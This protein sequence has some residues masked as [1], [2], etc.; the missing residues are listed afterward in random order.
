MPIDVSVVIPVYNTEKYLNQCIDSLVNQTLRNVEFI[1]VDDGSTD[2]SVEIIEEYKKHDD[3]IRLIKQKNQYA[4]VA[5]NNGMK[6]A[7]G[8]YI[9]FLD[10]DDFFELNMLEDAFNCAEKN[11]AEIAVFWYSTYDNASKEVMSRPY[12]TLPENVFCLQEVGER[13]LNTIMAAPWNK[14]FLRSFVEENKLLFQPIEKCNDTYFTFIAAFLAK[15]I[16]FIKMR[17]VFYRTNNNESLQGNNNKKR[18]AFIDCMK[19]IKSKLTSLGLYCGTSKNSYLSYSK[20]LIHLYGSLH[21]AQ[22]DSY[23]EY[24][25]QL[26]SHMIPDL[27]DSEIDFEDDP[28]I[29]HLY[30]DSFEQFMFYQVVSQDGIIIELKKKLEKEYVS[31]KSKDYLIGHAVMA[32]PRAVRG[33]F[34]KKK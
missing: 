21:N 19:A 5:R 8:K 25:E 33:V 24:F 20:D 4:G 29:V 18:E 16:T 2:R 23:R 27:F 1:F 11:Q 6:V 15:R 34:R 14:L 26:K 10:S 22:M 7:A 12:P 17:F 32:L 9:I 28:W 31:K 30:N 3:R 13:A